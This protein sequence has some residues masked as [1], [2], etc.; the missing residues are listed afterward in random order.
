MPKAGRA[1]EI[2]LAGAPE[3]VALRRSLTQRQQ[4]ARDTGPLTASWVSIDAGDAAATLAKARE[5]RAP[6]LK[7]Q[8]P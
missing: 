7:G 8:S 2:V 3:A 5:A 4:L 6:I 1:K